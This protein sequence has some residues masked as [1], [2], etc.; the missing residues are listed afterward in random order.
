MGRGRPTGFPEFIPFISR[1]A[2][3]THL[4]IDESPALTIV[5]QAHTAAILAA[6]PRRC[7]AKGEKGAQTHPERGRNR[8]PEGFRRVVRESH[9]IFLRKNCNWD[10]K[11]TDACP[12]HA[13]VDTVAA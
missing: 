10:G 8:T 4:F 13:Q 2:P 3:R 5:L 7:R 1:L 11:A 6:G 12:R 9:A